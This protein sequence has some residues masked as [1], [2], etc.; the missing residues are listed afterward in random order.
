MNNIL[1]I[2]N[3]NLSNLA[4]VRELRAFVA[5]CHHGSVTAAARVLALT[6]PAVSVLLRELERKLG[7]RLFERTTRSM[8]VSA[9]GREALVF[10]ERILKDLGDLHTGMGDAAAGRCGVVRIAATSALAQTV[11]PQIMAR[12]ADL[13]PQVRIELNDCA[14]DQFEHLIL[15]SQVDVGIGVIERADPEL[16]AQPLFHDRLCLVAPEQWPQPQKKPVTWQELAEYPLITLR[17][18]YGVRALIDQAAIQANVQLQIAYEVSLMG[19]AMALVGQGLGV[20]VLPQSLLHF[21]AFAG[22][23]A[24]RLV[25]P[26]ITRTISLVTRRNQ[27]FSQPHRAFSELS[28]QYFIQLR[29]E[30]GG[31]IAIRPAVGTKP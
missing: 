30:V 22:V 10:A 16:L 19:T 15:Q 13:Y 9:A 24:R 3:K 25:R 8:R 1:S 20:S 4:S 31:S 21:S 29:Q 28:Q 12:Y 27:A 14:P 7:V 18:G 5:I 26:A 23:H 6:G 11:L 2:A 17:S